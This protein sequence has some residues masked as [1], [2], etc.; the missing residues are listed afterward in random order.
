MVKEATCESFCERLELFKS[1]P[2]LGRINCLGL[3][4]FWLGI[5]TLGT[6]PAAVHAHDF[7]I[8]VG[9]AISMVAFV[10]VFYLKV[11]RLNDCNLSGWWLL[12]VLV[13]MVGCLWALLI[14]LIPGTKG[15]NNYGAQQ[16]APTGGSYLLLL[17]LP[18]AL[19]IWGWMVVLMGHAEMQHIYVFVTQFQN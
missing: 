10:N 2:R 5:L 9:L 12:L 15:K 16:A 14:Y 13:P 4:S 17:S 8:I 18:F 6:L 11:R 3:V 7:F 19:C 1:T